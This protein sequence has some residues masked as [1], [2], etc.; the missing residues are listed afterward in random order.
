VPELNRAHLAAQIALPHRLKLNEAGQIHAS[1]LVLEQAAAGGDAIWF[2]DDEGPCGEKTHPVQCRFDFS[3][4]SERAIAIPR[5]G[6][7]ARAG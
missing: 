2:T 4:G 6:L 7:L 1:D 5:L 3:S